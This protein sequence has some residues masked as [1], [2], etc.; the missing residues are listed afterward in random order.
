MT[1]TSWSLVRVTGL[2]MQYLYGE[3]GGW[4]DGKVRGERGGLNELL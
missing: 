2:A 4:V 1:P 3:V